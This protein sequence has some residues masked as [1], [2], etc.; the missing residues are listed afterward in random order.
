MTDNNDQICCTFGDIRDLLQLE[1][2]ANHKSLLVIGRMTSHEPNVEFAF[3]S[4]RLVSHD[5]HTSVLTLDKFENIA[6]YSTF[7]LFLKHFS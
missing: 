1:I 2:R 5:M 3:M 7:K 6:R 4:K